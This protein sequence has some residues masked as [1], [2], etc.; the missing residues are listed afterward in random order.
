VR[1]QILTTGDKF[2]H[3]LKQAVVLFPTIETAGEFF[4]ASAVRWPACHEYT[5]M[6]SG[7]KW[8]V[9]PISEVGDT[10]SVIAT[11]EDAAAQGGGGRALTLPIR[12]SRS[13]SSSPPM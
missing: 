3:Y 9:G 7:T 6:Q 13:P 2:T 5:H 8:T 12:R 10:L 1:D 11:F 4:D